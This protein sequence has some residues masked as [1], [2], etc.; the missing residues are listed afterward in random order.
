M[1]AIKNA[2]FNVIVLALNQSSLWCDTP[3]HTNANFNDKSP[4]LEPKIAST[5]N[6]RDLHENIKI[7]R[8]MR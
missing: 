1:K 3:L 8:I 2:L 7:H 6:V 5:E 4:L